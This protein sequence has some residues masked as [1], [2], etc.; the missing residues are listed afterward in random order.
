MHLAA[1]RQFCKLQD[2]DQSL[3]RAAMN[4][5]NVSARAYYRILK[6]SRTDCR[7]GRERRHSIFTS[8]GGV[9]VSAEVDDW[10]ISLLQGSWSSISRICLTRSRKWR[11]VL[12]LKA[13]SVYAYKFSL[14]S[15]ESLF[16]IIEVSEMELEIK[17]PD[18]DRTRYLGIDNG[19]VWFINHVLKTGFD[20]KQP[21]IP[22]M[23][24][25]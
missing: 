20:P 24:G 11:T 22:W 17:R 1:I 8:G 14:S 12:L 5:L 7:S 10:V 23:Q 21:R 15:S 9:A 3:I 2:E 13:N 16:W 6:L 18:G 19:I 4:Q 25:M